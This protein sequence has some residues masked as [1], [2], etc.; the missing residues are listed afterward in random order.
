MARFGGVP[1]EV[2]ILPLTVTG[3]VGDDI[4]EVRGVKKYE[5]PLPANLAGQVYGNFPTHLMPKT[6]E[7]NF[8]SVPEMVEWLRGKQ[9]YITVKADGSSATVYKLDGHF[10]CCSRNLEL[11]ETYNNA[12]WQLAKR[13][14]LAEVLPDGVA[15]QFE[16]IGEGIQGNPMGIKGVDCRVFNLYDIAAHEYLN[17]QTVRDLCQ[18]YGIPMVDIVDW[19][20]TFD[21]TSDEAIRRYAE[22]LYP[23]GKQREGVVI[24]PMAESRIGNARVSIKAINLLY[25]K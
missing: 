8:Q 1:S 14:K 24:R 5:K 10:G 22:G 19:D 2:L 11:K 18:K 21:F 12:I 20:K 7:P 13:Y 17:G 15:I 3:E 25:G 16:T 6:D 4:S 23:N 9:V